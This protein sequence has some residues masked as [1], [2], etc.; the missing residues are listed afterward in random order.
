MVL[1]VSNIICK[2]RNLKFCTDKTS[3]MV[4]T[5]RKLTI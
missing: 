4:F 5:V 1:Y 2:K 3:V